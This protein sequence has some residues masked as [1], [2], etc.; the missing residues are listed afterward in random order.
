[1][2]DLQKPG[3]FVQTGPSTPRDAHHDWDEEARKLFQRLNIDAGGGRDK[4]RNVDAVYCHPTT[5]AKLFIGN[6]T[7]ARSESV[8]VGEA[9]FHVVNCQDASSANFFEGD[10]RF[11]YRRFPVSHWWQHDGMDAPDGV[12]KF[13]EDGCHGWIADALAG[14]HNVMVHCLAGAHRAGT[15]GVSFMMRAAPPRPSFVFSFFLGVAASLGEGRFDTAT[16]IKLAKF[17]RPI[18][19][20]FG[21]LHELLMRLEAAY[22]AKGRPPVAPNADEPSS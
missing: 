8:L 11:H 3:L 13:F 18:V 20:P 4:Y 16:A 2:M 7:A 19:D 6:Q 1:M 15:T 17:Q 14:G 10:P 9:I 21:Q 5:G 12:L 22:T